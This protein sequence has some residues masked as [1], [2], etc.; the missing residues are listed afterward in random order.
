MGHHT[1]L[2]HDE[3]KCECRPHLACVGSHQCQLTHRLARFAHRVSHDTDS[4]VDGHPAGST[5]PNQLHVFSNALRRGISRRERSEL[6]AAVASHAIAHDVQPQRVVDEHHVFVVAALAAHVGFSDPHDF[7]VTLL[8]SGNARR[9]D[10]QLRE[11]RAPTRT[12]SAG[13]HLVESNFSSAARRC[14]SAS[15]AALID[16]AWM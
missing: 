9:L 4:H 14:A 12:V 1:R 15:P 10:L 6:A 13:G 2:P 8:V 11:P 5:L 7:H 3:Q 16:H